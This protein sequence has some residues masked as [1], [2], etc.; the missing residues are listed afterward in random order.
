ML[1]IIASLSA[2][3]SEQDDVEP[4]YETFIAT[5]IEKAGNLVVVE[6]FTGE[7]ELNSSDRIQFGTDKIAFKGETGDKVRI[8]YNGVIRESYPAQI[9]VLECEH[10]TD[11]RKANFAGQWLDETYL[12]DTQPLE[13]V[14]RIVGTITDIYG[15]CFFGSTSGNKD[16]YKFNGALSENWCIGDVVNVSSERMLKDEKRGMLEATLIQVQS[17]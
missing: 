15:D 14:W 11:F 13:T 10:Y 9:D 16:V 12:D 17:Y 1:F 4:T 5:V 7:E 2:C 6:P 3:E 8:T